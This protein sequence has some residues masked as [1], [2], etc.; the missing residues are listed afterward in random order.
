MPLTAA[1]CGFRHP[2]VGVLAGH[3]SI[4]WVVP[5]FPG[6]HLPV[7]DTL[8]QKNLVACAAKGYDIGMAT[9]RSML[10][11]ALAVLAGGADRAAAWRFPLRRAESAPEP[12]SEPELDFAPWRPPDGRPVLSIQEEIERLCDADGNIEQEIFV[13]KPLTPEMRSEV[14][15]WRTRFAREPIVE[16]YDR[17]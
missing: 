3:S 16:S 5:G 10:M 2:V 17:K 12:E 8:L 13:C 6:S 1:P 11:M 4:P 7:D 14:M 9:R 15:R